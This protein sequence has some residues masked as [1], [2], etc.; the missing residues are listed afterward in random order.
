MYFNIMNDKVIIIELGFVNAYLLKAEKGFILIDTG[1]PQQKEQ[2]ENGLK[3]AGC[4]PENLKLVIITHGD[5]DH[6][7]NAAFIKEKYHAK[8]AVHPE[9]VNQAEYGIFLKRKIKPLI[10]KIF[11]AIRMLKRKLQKDET[12]FLKFKT[13]IQLSDGQRLDEYGPNAKIIHIPGH[14]EG[15]IGVLTDDGDFFAGDTFVNY[16]KPATASIIQNQ[17]ELRESIDKIK[18]LNIVTVFPGHGKPFPIK[19]LF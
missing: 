9:D 10:F 4:T 14:T 6:T 13:D 19:N 15:S 1:L 18:K 2:L 17:K 7:G 8:I 11:F 12:P 16:K 5:W 3:S